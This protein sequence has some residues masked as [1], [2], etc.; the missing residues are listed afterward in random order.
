MADYEFDDDELPFPAGDGGN[1]GEGEE[2][3]VALVSTRDPVPLR[4][5]QITDE[6]TPDTM[7]CIGTFFGDRLIARRVVPPEVLQEIDARRVFAQPVRVALAA[8]ERPPGLQCQLFALI[9]AEAL[10]EEPEEPQEPWAAS[11]PRYEDVI[12]ADD[13][14]VEESEE[15]EDMLM[16]VPLGQIVR[17]DANRKHPDDLSR[18]AADVLETVLDYSQPLTEVV[19]KVLED[20]LGEVRDSDEFDRPDPTED[21]SP[22]QAG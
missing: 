3:Q 2:V 8:A 22:P 12:G 13:A 6:R 19:D 9:P 18:E 5:Q 17:F 16:A 1:G 14:E 7:I 11:V 21:D 4:L 10:E 20:L 15:E